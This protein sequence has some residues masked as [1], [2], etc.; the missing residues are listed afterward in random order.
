MRLVQCS[1]PARLVMLL[2]EALREV[3][4]SRSVGKM[5]PSDLLIVTLITASRLESAIVPQ[6]ERL[7]IRARA[8]DRCTNFLNIYVLLLVLVDSKIGVLYHLFS[9]VMNRRGVRLL[10]RAE[11]IKT[12]VR[13]LPKITSIRDVFV[14]FYPHSVT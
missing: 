10:F 6:A 5:G 13:T 4:P 11:A 1:N 2:F 14:R 9:Q 7:S 12:S 8:R 3:S